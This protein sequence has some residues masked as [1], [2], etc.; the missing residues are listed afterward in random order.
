MWFVV[1]GLY[2][3]CLLVVFF[4][5]VIVFVCLGIFVLRLLVGCLGIAVVWVLQVVGFDV[6]CIFALLGLFVI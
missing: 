5:Y 2:I 4:V 3:G 1:T 6:W